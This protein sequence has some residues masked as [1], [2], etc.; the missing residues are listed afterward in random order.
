MYSAKLPSFTLCACLPVGLNWGPLAASKWSV[1][2]RF[3]LF[4]RSEARFLHFPLVPSVLFAPVPSAAIRNG[5]SAKD[6]PLVMRC[7][8]TSLVLPLV[9][10]VLFCFPPLGR[11]QEWKDGR[12][13]SPFHEM[14][15]NPFCFSPIPLAATK[16][17]SQK[18]RRFSFRSVAQRARIH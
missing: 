11:D 18:Q 5:R 3:S 10:S 12:R 13:F 1:S 2:K 14:R 6:F 17:G 8:A 4:K 7:K 9:P 16:N 15:S